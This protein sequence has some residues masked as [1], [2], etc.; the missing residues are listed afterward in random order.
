M[1]LILLY[2]NYDER[3][4]ASNEDD[5]DDDSENDNLLS[6]LKRFSYEMDKRFYH[7]SFDEHV[8]SLSTVDEE[9]YM[10]D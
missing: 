4:K 10:Y 3:P 5:D 8:R 1:Q 7:L 9:G 6:R 2:G